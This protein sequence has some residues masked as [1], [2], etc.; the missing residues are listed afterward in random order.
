MEEK[1]KNNLHYLTIF[2][3]LLLYYNIRS[4]VGHLQSIYEILMNELFPISINLKL[5]MYAY[6]IIFH[7]FFRERTKKT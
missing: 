5:Y 4:G 1:Q 6:N 7:L 2:F 3:T